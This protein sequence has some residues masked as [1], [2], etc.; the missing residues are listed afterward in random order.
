[1]D[2]NGLYCFIADE[3]FQEMFDLSRRIIT[4]RCVYIRTCYIKYNTVWRK[5]AVK[6][7]DE[8]KNWQYKSTED[9]FDHIP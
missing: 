1:M 7:Q 8:R 4:A 3:E 9:Y 2:Q 6:Q 5:Y